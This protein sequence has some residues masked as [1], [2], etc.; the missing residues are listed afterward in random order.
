MELQP[1][2]KVLGL[3]FLGPSPAL[4]TGFEKGIFCPSLGDQFVVAGLQEDEF[5]YDGECQGGLE[6]FLV[7]PGSA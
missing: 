5:S 2:E 3:G 6:L 1:G 7:F 4:L